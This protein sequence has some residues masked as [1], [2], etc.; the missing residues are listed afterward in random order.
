MRTPEEWANHFGLRPGMAEFFRLC[1]LD[2][3]KWAFDTCKGNDY[4]ISVIGAKCQSLE[5]PEPNIARL[6]TEGF[7]Q[8]KDCQGI[9]TRTEDDHGQPDFCNRCGS[10]RL[11]YH[12]PI[13]ITN[14][15]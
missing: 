1:Q 13:L 6:A 9:D 12:E 15:P 4:S 11:K 3:L 2:A 10:H 8:C 14:P 7:W 5:R